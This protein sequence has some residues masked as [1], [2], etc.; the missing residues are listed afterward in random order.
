MSHTGQIWLGTSVEKGALSNELN[1]VSEWHIYDLFLFVTSIWTY[2]MYLFLQE[3][4]DICFIAIETC[5]LE[6]RCS[7]RCLEK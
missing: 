2:S 5:F 7:G 4:V 6:K 1:K 3:D